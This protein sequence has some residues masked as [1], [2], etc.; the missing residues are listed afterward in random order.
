MKIVNP[1]NFTLIL[2]FSIF[3]S[4]SNPSKTNGKIKVGLQP[5]GKFN[6]EYLAIVADEIESNYGFEVEILPEKEMFKNAFVNIKSPRYQAN[7]ILRELKSSRPDSLDYII[8]LTNF[9]IST[10]KRDKLGNVKKPESKY[11]DWGV[12]GLGLMPGR[13]C[14]ISTFRLKS[15]KISHDKFIERLKKVCVHELGHNLGLKHCEHDPKCVMRD[16]AET[17]KTVDNVSPTLC[18]H[19]RNE[20]ED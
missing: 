9:D 16:A 20:I 2:A 11:L 3:F 5:L 15:K 6:K 8:G 12:L 10:T 17:V 18:K 13:V 4:C 1:L 14:V 7:T 19:C